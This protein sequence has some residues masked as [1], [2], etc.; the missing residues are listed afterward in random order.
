MQTDLSADPQTPLWQEPQ[1]RSPGDPKRLLLDA[2]ADGE[3][4]EHLAA[5]A[6]AVHARREL[7]HTVR[8]ATALAEL[9]VGDPV[10][11]NRHIRP[12]YLS[13][14]HGQIT[15]LDDHWVT[16]RLRRPIGRFRSGEIRCPP[17]ALTKLDRATYRPAA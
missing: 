4:D 8:A 10:R 16:V 1:E 9:C 6:D 15:E 14:E 11:I 5:L 17:L 12:R 13:G 7:L 2:I 3:L